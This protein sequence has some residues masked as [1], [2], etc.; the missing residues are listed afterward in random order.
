MRVA[1]LE[2]SEVIESE[3]DDAP[4]RSS[5]RY[6]SAFGAGGGVYVAAHRSEP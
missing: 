1:P 3:V 2:P 5:E 4:R 6:A